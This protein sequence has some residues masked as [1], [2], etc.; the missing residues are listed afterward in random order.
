MRLIAVLTACVLA[1]APTGALGFESSADDEG[2]FR[3]ML[4]LMHTVVGIAAQSE[5]PKV[6]E[7]RMDEVFAGRNPEAN[8]AAAGLLGEM[9]RD[10][11]DEER[12]SFVALAQDILALARREHARAIAQPR[13]LATRDA[14]RVLAARKELNAMGLRYYDAG[15]FLDAVK[16]DDALAVAL[17][18]EGRGVNLEARDADGRTALEIAQAKGNRQIVALLSSAR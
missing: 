16:R 9:T 8:R 10:M 13:P 6:V 17:Y 14:E 1:W 7:K 15:Q 12:E 3:H 11:T 4:A 18:V 5:D 2:G